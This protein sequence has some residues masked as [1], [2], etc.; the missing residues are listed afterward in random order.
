MNSCG[1]KSI[2]FDVLFSEPSIYRNAKQDEIIDNAVKALEEASLESAERPAAPTGGRQP[3]NSGESSR[4]RI[5][6]RIAIDAL[7]SLNAREDDNSFIRSSQNFGRVVQAVLFSQQTGS[8]VTWPSGVNTPLFQ[9]EGFGSM[10]EKFRVGENEKGQ[11]PIQGIR[12]TTGALGSVTGIPDSDGIIRRLKL[13][14][15]FDG[16]AVPGLSA[17]SFLVSGKS[18]QI[19]YNEKTS[20]L[21]WEDISIPIDKNGYALLRFRGQ[22]DR[23]IPYRAMQILQSAEAFERGEEPLVLPSNFKDAYVFFGF[24]AQGLFDIFSTPISAVYPGTGCHITMLDNILM[25]DFIRETTEW[26][27]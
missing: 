11:F 18:R 2:A 19:S 8:A 25:G 15:L 12:E 26:F 24:Y 14:T 23:Y 27:N 16:K 6:F 1:A 5:A 20:S 7:Q 3:Q 22:V 4:P 9:P 21:E 13:F 10:L 17:A